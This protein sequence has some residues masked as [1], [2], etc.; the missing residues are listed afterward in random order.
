MPGS[1]LQIFNDYSMYDEGDGGGVVEAQLEIDINMFKAG[2]CNIVEGVIYDS[3]T[4]ETPDYI[5]LSSCNGDR[6]KLFS[7]GR[8]LFMPAGGGESWSFRLE[9]W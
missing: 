1:A 2:T 7:D 4:E 8:S 9:S 3:V 6:I 5:L